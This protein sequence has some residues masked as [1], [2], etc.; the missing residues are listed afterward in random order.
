V[1]GTLRLFLFVYRPGEVREH[2]PSILQGRTG[3]VHSVRRYAAGHVRRGG[4][5]ETGLGREGLVGRR[6]ADTVRF[7]GEQS[8]CTHTNVFVETYATPISI[9]R[10]I[11]EL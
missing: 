3:S 10:T 11:F 9:V 4:Q 5:V 6:Y 2:D 8:K 1:A 7:T